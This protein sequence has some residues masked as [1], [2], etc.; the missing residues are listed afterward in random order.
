MIVDRLKEISILLL[1]LEGEVPIKSCCKNPG[2]VL[3]EYSVA[4]K[5]EREISITL[6]QSTLK[7]EGEFS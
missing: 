1:K 5:L 7:L 3:A 2:C 4:L 6:Q